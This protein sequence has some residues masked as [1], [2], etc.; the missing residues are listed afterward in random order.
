MDE[1]Q[2]DDLFR[3]LR[4]R[5]SREA[6]ARFLDH[7]SPLLLDVV[8]LFEREDDAVGDCY[9]F[10]CEQLSCDGF[11]RLL[12]F[13]PDG[14]A[15]FSTWLCAVARNLCLDW[16]RREFGRH[17]VFESVARLPALDQEVFR[18]VFVDRLPIDDAFLKLAPRFPGLTVEQV[19]D[20][21]GRIQQA[22]TSR[23]RW[24]LMAQRSRGF[25]GP[26]TMLER[27]ETELGQIPSEMPNPETWAGMQE[28]RSALLR[29]MSKL[30]SRER[31]L[32]RLR[33][34]REATLEEIANLLGLGN[35][36]SADRRIRE[37]VEK[38]RKEMP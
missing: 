31:L 29:A 23:Q 37:A 22:L 20:G 34:E 27:D 26:G 2:A 36:Q 38:L 10:I 1:L 13:R 3:Q 28:E 30:S 9:L 8:R 15:R 16:H 4:S 6:W 24:L 14:P 32:I 7:Y 5:E 35:A 33:Y 17:R 19:S 18:C 21:V 12:R 25:R 11:R